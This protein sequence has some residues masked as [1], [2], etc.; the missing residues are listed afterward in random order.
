MADENKLFRCTECGRLVSAV[1]AV[2]NDPLQCCGK[3]MME[4]KEVFIEEK[5]GTHTPVMKIE[6]N[7]I[8]VN[9]GAKPHAMEAEHYIELI[10]V[11]RGNDLV[12]EK[13]LNPGEKP[14]A[15][16]FVENTSGISA[17]SLC[18]LHGLWIS[19]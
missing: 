13:K 16:F 10:Q 2:C 3:P 18:D 11:M 14:E 15:V 4:L 6:G 1:K 12:A 17:R 7:K 8:T 19:K 5:T 9:V